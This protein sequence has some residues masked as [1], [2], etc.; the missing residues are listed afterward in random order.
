M[1]N[2]KW[3]VASAEALFLSKTTCLYDAACY[4]GPIQHSEPIMSQPPVK[5]T[6]VKITLPSGDL[7]VYEVTPQHLTYKTGLR[8]SEFI[9][10]HGIQQ[11]HQHQG[12]WRKRGGW[13]AITDKRTIAL[14][15]AATSIED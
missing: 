15:D 8:R 3:T 1:T 5:S 12:I 4:N 14:L 2:P 11:A 13:E 6:F 9:R 7:A 10:Q